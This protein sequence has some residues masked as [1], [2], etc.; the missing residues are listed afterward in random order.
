MAAVRQVESDLAAQQESLRL[1]QAEAF[2]VA[3]Q[4]T[5]VRNEITALDLQKQGNV[6]RPS[7]SFRRKKFNWKKNDPAWKRGCRNS[8]PMLKPRS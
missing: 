1:A 5:R 3:Q 7:K 8:P 2:S 4:L 6:V